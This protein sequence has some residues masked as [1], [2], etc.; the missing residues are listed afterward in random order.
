MR[1]TSIIILSYNT[2]EYTRLCIESIREYT[3]K[4]CYEIIVVDNASEDGSVEWL[5]QQ[6]DIKLLENRE[7]VGFPL[8]CNQGMRASE[9]GNDLLL[10]NSD[11][12]V[13]PRWLD[14][15]QIALYS[16]AKVGAVSCVTNCCSNQQAIEVSYTTL[17]EMLSFA[18]E[19]NHSDAQKWYTWPTLVGFCFLVK[20]EVY[21]M[22][23]GLDERYSPGN[24]EDDDYSFT[25]RQAGFRLLLCADTFIQHFGSASFKQ[26][27]DP[28]KAKVKEELFAEIMRKNKAKFL[29]K[30]QVNYD[31]KVFHGITGVLQPEDAEKKVLLIRCSVGL[32]LCNLQRKYPKMRLS[33]IVFNEIESRLA[34]RDFSIRY[35]PDWERITAGITI[36]QDIIIVLGNSLDIPNREQVFDKLRHHLHGNGKL[37]YGENEQ[38]FL[39]RR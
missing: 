5:H 32:D 18:E 25:I 21:E 36:R 12:I 10:L 22:I 19:Y 17:E 6:K 1:K 24:Y 27:L 13:T 2:L 9:P 33:G 8:G 23:G 39:E 15:L 14:N 26:D 30:W 28:I 20:R 34:V 38:V 16:D 37:F 29:E 4:N 11:T 31:Y 3:P 7:N 35:V